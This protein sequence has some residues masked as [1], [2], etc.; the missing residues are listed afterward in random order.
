MKIMVLLDKSRLCAMFLIP[1]RIRFLV[2]P[3]S[4]YASFSGPLPAEIGSRAGCL[5]AHPSFIKTCWTLK[6]MALLGS[7]LLMLLPNFTGALQWGYE[8]GGSPLKPRDFN[9]ALT[10]I[11]CALAL[12]NQPT[13]CLPAWG[14]MTIPLFRVLDAAFLQRYEH[15]AFGGHSIFVMMLAGY[16]LTSVMALMAL[17]TPKGKLI[18][19]WVA[20]CTIILLSL[21]NIYEWLGFASFTRIPGRMA[22]WHI[23]PNHSPI[24][25][26]LMTGV[27]FTWC[28]RFWFNMAHVGL[29]IFAIAVTMSRSGMAVFAAILAAYLLVHFRKHWIGLAV[30]AGLSVPVLAV[31]VAVLGASNERQG[32]AKNEDTTSRMQAIYEL[33]FEKLKSPERAKDLADGWEAVMG[34]PLFG[35]GMGAG[36]IRWAPHNQFVMQW[37]EL[38]IPGLVHYAG[39]LI[40]VTVVCVMRRF[41]A[42]YC[43]LPVWLF[44][45]CSQIL[46][47]TPPY[48]FAFAVAVMTLFP[49]RYALS[50]DRAAH[51]P[52][53]PGHA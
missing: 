28:G 31:G 5:E 34:K 49:K 10:F 36:D 45:P 32:L 50:L 41:R 23:D 52:L 44:I 24:I 46:L 51:Q 2:Q 38:G 12:W 40:I 37:L 35:H 39:I 53:P 13:L 4:P 30:V 17:S 14:L 8:H 33:D 21:V 25:I 6:E 29:S 18:A 48:W 47:E 11:T 43:L 7:V 15:L 20:S 9:L 27:L 3:H 19:L 26:C 22:G 42:V 1:S 16:F